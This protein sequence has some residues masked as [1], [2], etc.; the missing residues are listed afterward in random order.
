MVEY[1]E[2]NCKLT[3]VQLNK[4][5]KAV[6]S[7]EGATLRLG[8][9][10]FNKNE[11]PHELLLTTRQNTELRNAISNNLT[12]DIKLSKAQIKKIIQSGGFLGKLL[13]KLAGPLMKVA[14]PLAKNVLAALGLT[15]AMSAID[16]GIRKKIHGSGVKLIIEQEDMKDIMKIIKALENSGIL[17]K[18]VSK[19]IKNETKEQR[20]GFLSMLLGTLGA[21]LLGNLLTGGKGIMRAGDGIVR[22]GE[23][24]V[25]SRAKSDGS[26]KTLNSLLPFHPLTNIEISEYYKNEPRFNGVYS[27]NN[28]PNKIKKGAYVINLDKYENTGTHWVSL[29][30]KPKY[31]VYFDSF[32]VEHIPKEINKFIR[33]KE[34]G[35]AVG[36]KK[37]KTSIFRIQAYDSIMCG[38]FC[39]EFINY[40]LQGKT[41]LDYTNLFSPNDFKKNDQNIKRIFKNEYYRIN[42]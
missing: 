41:L 7:N 40:M 26:K 3:N 28:L 4:L 22:A 38:Y 20:G 30:V 32:G 29:F 23:G 19:A 9:K 5:K 34:L 39:I 24:N 21:S 14:L 6:K 42:R 11:H 8:I 33:S 31:T 15:A 1:S 18:G 16:G 25:V 27:R 10:N 35:P 17:L 36:N 12:T 13:S 37:I 2:I